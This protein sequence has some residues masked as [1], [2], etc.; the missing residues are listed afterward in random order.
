[1]KLTY[2][3]HEKVMKALKTAYHETDTVAING[4]WQ[5]DIMRDIRRVGP[6][7]LETNGFASF[8][9]FLWR[10]VPVVSV[11]I[12]IVSGLVA[13]LDVM[14][15]YELGNLLFEDSETTATVDSFFM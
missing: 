1:M 8:T 5:Q 14:A 10:A 2:K 15:D 6:F 13:N 3:D 12:L 4:Q 9:Q 11:L 7:G